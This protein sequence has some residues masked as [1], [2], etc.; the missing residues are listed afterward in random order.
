MHENVIVKLI[1]WYNEYML[2]KRI[3]ERGEKKGEREKSQELQPKEKNPDF[4]VYI[5]MKLKLS[6]D[7][8][9]YRFHRKITQTFG[10]ALEKYQM[11]SCS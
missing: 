7:Y 9:S 2:I 8:I 5:H 3:K 6:S 4:F 1:I 10:N 11:C